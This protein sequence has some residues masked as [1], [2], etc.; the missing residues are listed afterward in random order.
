MDAIF[1]PNFSKDIGKK[2]ILERQNEFISLMLISGQIKILKK[3]SKI[4][5]LGHSEDYMN[6][7]DLYFD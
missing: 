2:S 1:I 4:I 7:R 5:N 6:V 3:I